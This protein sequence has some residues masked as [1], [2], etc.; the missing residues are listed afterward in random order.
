MLKFDDLMQFDVAAL[1]RDAQRK[2]GAPCDLPVALIEA[3]PGNIRKQC[4][5]SQIAALADTIKTDGL[6]HAIVVRDHP[7]KPGRYLVSYGERRFRA[8]RLL[9]WHTI[10]AVINNDFDPYRQAIENLQREDLHPL[11]IAE[12]VAG[13]ESAGDTR[14]EIARR[15]GKPK[16][17]ISEIAQ[18]ADAPAEI[19]EAFRSRRIPD[20]RTAY[21]LSRGIRTTPDAVRQLLTSDLQITRAQ[22][23]KS[24]GRAPT[25]KHGAEEG[26][27]TSVLDPRPGSTPSVALA[28]DVDGRVGLMRLRPGKSQKHGVVCFEDGSERSVALERLRLQSWAVL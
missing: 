19:K 24:L 15:L 16:S 25:R 27:R 20:L 12:W 22:A 17:Y 2:S 14:A 10:A 3:D 11:D 4:D 13:R 21:L 7:D 5:Q 23:T 18:L 28:V 1:G 9:G 6:L 26:E 8:V